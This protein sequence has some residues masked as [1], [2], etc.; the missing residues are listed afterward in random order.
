MLYFITL[1]LL[2]IAS[3]S[4]NSRLVEINRIRITLCSIPWTP[5]HRTVPKM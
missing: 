4:V 3:K 1:K 5:L 2:Y